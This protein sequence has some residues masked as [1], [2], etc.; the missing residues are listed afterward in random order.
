VLGG[1]AGGLG[2]GKDVLGMM[3]VLRCTLIFLSLVVIRLGIP[4]LLFFAPI[5]FSAAFGLN[6]ISKE[7]RSSGNCCLRNGRIPIYTFGMGRLW[8]SRL[9]ATLAA[10]QF[11][12]SCVF[13]Q[14]VP[15]V[16]SIALES[17]PI[18]SESPISTESTSP[19]STPSR[20][21][22]VHIVKTGAGGF[23]LDPQE[24]HNVSVGDIVSFEF[25]PTGHSIARAEYASACSPYEYTGKGKV[26][27]WS[28]EISVEDVD[29]V[30]HPNLKLSYPHP[31]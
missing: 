25:Y 8:Y 12:V 27:F 15:S 6:H 3:G 22:Q 13:A 26:G 21:P 10:S 19:T 1:L 7:S 28:G 5:G 31:R 24:I 9:A 14:E 30:C 23:K 18:P 16:S 4:L 29:H 11:L 20:E 2:A 17:L